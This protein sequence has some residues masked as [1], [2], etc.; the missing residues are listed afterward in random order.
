MLQDPI[1]SN[2]FLSTLNTAIE[3]LKLM[4]EETFEGN[5]ELNDPEL[6]KTGQVGSWEKF[7][8]EMREKYEEMKNSKVQMILDTID[9][10]RRET[11][12]SVQLAICILRKRME[13][14]EKVL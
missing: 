6:D 14:L 8:K 13:N 10:A 4:V 1:V 11:K 3:K 12:L 2:S 9:N 5:V 7:L